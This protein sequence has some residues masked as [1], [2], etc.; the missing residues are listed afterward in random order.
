MVVG[1]DLSR[2]SESGLGE[3][4]QRGEEN[5][6]KVSPLDERLRRKKAG[7]VVLVV[8]CGTSVIS[9]GRCG[10]V[11]GGRCGILL[12]LGGALQLQK[13]RGKADNIAQ[14]AE[15]LEAADQSNGGCLQRRH[16]RRASRDGGGA[17]R[18]REARECAGGGP[19][20]QSSCRGSAAVRRSGGGGE[21]LLE[22]TDRR[23]T[24]ATDGGGRWCRGGREWRR[25]G[26][27]NDAAATVAKHNKTAGGGLLF[28]VAA[29][30]GLC[31]GGG[32]CAT[33]EAAVVG[34]D[35]SAVDAVAEQCGDAL[36][37]LAQVEVEEGRGL[38]QEG[39]Q[40]RAAVV[41]GSGGVGKVKK[42]VNSC[43]G[44]GRGLR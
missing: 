3:E 10:R 12:L 8:S 28:V 24:T 40:Q 11:R 26:G 6:D 37:Q 17:N 2:R 36:H 39:Q 23:R 43:G 5:A 1:A 9:S 35:C 18:R 34:A 20:V 22:G 27:G 41:G 21:E 29:T 4:L 32:L 19:V 30:L 44:A 33:E 31:G 13:R 25:G 42:G 16:E 14:V 38:G 15:D 7:A